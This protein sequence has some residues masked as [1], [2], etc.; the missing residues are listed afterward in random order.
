MP[1]SILVV[2]AHPDDE[3]LGCGAT[4]A[5]HTANKESVSV[6]TLTGGTASR[7]ESKPADETARREA[8]S[9]AMEVLG[10]KWIGKGNFPD[11]QLDTVPLLD[12][13]KYLESFKKKN[14]YDLIYTHSLGDLNIDHKLTAQAVI[15]AFRPQPNE[16]FNEILSFEIPSSTEYS[17]S[18]LRAAFDPNVFID[19]EDFFEIKLCALKHYESEMKDYPHPRSYEALENLAKYRGSSSGLRMAEAFR[20]IKKIYR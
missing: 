1:K 10:A 5:K 12:I 7:D 11:N 20:L 4:I 2:A 9:K 19:I 13:V 16:T 18:E 8:A 14:N 15:T 3:T 17:V 6:V